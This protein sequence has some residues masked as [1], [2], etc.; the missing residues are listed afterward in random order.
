MMRVRE[1]AGGDLVNSRYDFGAVAQEK[2]NCVKKGKKKTER[3][4]FG[5]IRDKQTFKTE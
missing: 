5:S 2:Y 3:S 4:A 1:G